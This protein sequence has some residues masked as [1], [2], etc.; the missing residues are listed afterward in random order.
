MLRVFDTFSPLTQITLL[1]G[2]L[3][4]LQER[5]GG[6]HTTFLIQNHPFCHLILWITWFGDSVCTSK[7]VI[8]IKIIEMQV[9]NGFVH[10]KVIA[11]M[12]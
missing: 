1:E 6:L 10:K 5:L 4:H 11:L 8:D 9:K 12:L 3:K 2:T 7:N